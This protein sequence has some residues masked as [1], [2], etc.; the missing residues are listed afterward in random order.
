MKARRLISSILISALIL[1]TATCTRTGPDQSAN[2]TLKIGIPAPLA[3]G[4]AEYGEFMRQGAM[5]AADEINGQG[6]VNGR[7][8]ELVFEDSQGQAAEATNAAEKLLVRDKVLVMTDAFNSNATI[9]AAEVAKRE[10]APMVVGLSTA[11]SITASGN[12]YVFRVCLPNTRLAEL[13]GDYITQHDKPG[14]AAYV[15]EKTEFGTNLANVVRQRLEQ[16]GVKTVANEGINQHDTD[17]LSLVTKLKPL[18]PDMVFLAVIADSALPFLRQAR[19]SGF[20]ARWANAVSLSNPKFLQDAG[21]LAD[22]FIGITHFEATTAQGDAKAFAEKFQAK[23]GRP[24]THYS[25][26]YYDTIRVIADAV[27]R[28]GAERDGVLNALK[29]TDFAGITGRIRF[30]AQGQ[31]SIGT[32]IFRWEN[33]RKE[34]L[35]V[36]QGV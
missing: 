20:R 9:A 21:A 13:I 1:L 12:P 8:F 23:Y 31:A 29:N 16:A 28:G 35:R 30:N 27:R 36:N 32:V 6:G 17:F 7:N 26:V 33:G 4:S 15:F 2:P 10:K 25:A 11:D 22:G 14:T 24:P 18:Q 3:G 5:I 34:I 19:E